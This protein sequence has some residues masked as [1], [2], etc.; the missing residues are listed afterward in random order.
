MW[1]S[2][3]KR[4]QS[5]KPK[6]P[7]KPA[8]VTFSHGVSIPEDEFYAS[9]GR[10]VPKKIRLRDFKEDDVVTFSHGASIPSRQFYAA[11]G[12]KY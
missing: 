7:K 5:K 1:R 6:Q 11:L 8:M 9:I 3:K 4:R 2:T 12:H 10:P